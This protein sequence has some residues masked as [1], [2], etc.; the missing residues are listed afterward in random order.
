MIFFGG[1]FKARSFSISNSYTN[2]KSD[3]LKGKMKIH[4]ETTEYKAGK[5]TVVFYKNTGIYGN[6]KSLNLVTI[7]KRNTKQK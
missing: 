2:I 1:L 3:S 7:K 6:L 4:K 5:V